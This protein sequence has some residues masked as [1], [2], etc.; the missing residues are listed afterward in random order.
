MLRRILLILSVVGLVGSAGLWAVSYANIA[1]YRGASAFGLQQGAFS[2]YLP[3]LQPYKEKTNIRPPPGRI[4]RNQITYTGYSGLETQWRL[5][6]GSATTIRWLEVPLWIP[7]FIFSI[8]AA[9]VWASYRRHR[10]R[11]GLCA[12]CGY[13]LRGSPG[14]C[15]ECGHERG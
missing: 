1:Y 11:L 5:S 13:D 15:S 7:T 14:P 3:G 4:V 8:L 9:P 12:G 10:R 6:F 2:V